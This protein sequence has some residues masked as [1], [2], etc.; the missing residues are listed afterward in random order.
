MEANGDWS[1]QEIE[2]GE[3]TSGTEDNTVEG[4]SKKFIGTYPLRYLNLCCKASGLCPTV[5]IFL[6]E[7]HMPIFLVYSVAAIGVLKIGLAPK[8]SVDS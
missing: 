2:I 6:K 5:E 3:R 1:E 7:D 4:S 8:V